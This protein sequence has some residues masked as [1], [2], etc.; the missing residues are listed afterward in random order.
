MSAALSA[1]ESAPSAAAQRPRHLARRTLARGARHE[2]EV[3]EAY[4]LGRMRAAHAM[5]EAAADAVAKLVH[6]DLAGRYSIAARRAAGRRWNFVLACN[7]RIAVLGIRDY[8]RR[9]RSQGE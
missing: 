8:D 4:F 6:F 3:D 9:Q 1:P 7:T 2:A 5:A